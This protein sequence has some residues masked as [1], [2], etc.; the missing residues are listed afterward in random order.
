M[1]ALHSRSL[2][3]WAEGGC[4]PERF[5]VAGDKIIVLVHVR[6]RLKDNVEWLDGR[7]ADVYTFRNGKVIQKRTFFGEPQEALEWAGV[8]ASDVP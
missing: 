5:I 8:E 7:L 1:E 6:V 2:A 4:E 3:N